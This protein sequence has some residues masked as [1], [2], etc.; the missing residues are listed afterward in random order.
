MLQQV[1]PQRLRSGLRLRRNLAIYLILS[2]SIA[3]TFRS[4]QLININLQSFC[5]WK[6]RSATSFHNSY[7]MDNDCA[8]TWLF[9]NIRSS[10]NYCPKQTLSGWPK[11]WN[12]HT[13]KKTS[14]RLEK[15]TW[16]IHLWFYSEKSFFATKAQA[17]NFENIPKSLFSPQRHKASKVH[18]VYSTD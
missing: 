4:G 11:K 8:L 9:G 6:S 5:F 17:S 7:K 15:N 16:R 13:L 2:N 10:Q 1:A 14:S 18:K 12:R 3:L